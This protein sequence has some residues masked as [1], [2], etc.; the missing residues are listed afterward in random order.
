M[1]KRYFIISLLIALLISSVGYAAN[2]DTSG[3]FTYAIKGNGTVEITGFDWASNRQ[4][5]YVPQY[6]DGYS[7]TSI[8][9]KAFA[10]ETE[11]G[12]RGYN[13]EK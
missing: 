3:L 10:R 5:I 2:T 7:V 8:G 11:V 12:Y 13:L 1:K 4:D 6:I 9:E